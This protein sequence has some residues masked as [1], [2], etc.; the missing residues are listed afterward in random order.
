MVEYEYANNRNNEQIEASL[1]PSGEKYCCIECNKEMY[2]VNRGRIQTPHFRH[3]VETDSIHE[4][5]LHFNTKHL[6]YDYVNSFFVRG[7]PLYVEITDM[8]GFTHWYNILNN[9]ENIQKERAISNVYRPD[10]SIIGKNCIFSIEIVDTHSLSSTAN[11][12]IIENNINLIKLNVTIDVYRKIQNNFKNGINVLFASFNYLFTPFLSPINIVDISGPCVENKNNFDITHFNCFYYFGIDMFNT[13]SKSLEDYKLSIYENDAEKFNLKKKNELSIVVDEINKL[14]RE[15]EIDA[16]N[17]NSKKL[18]P[19][20]KDATKFNLKKQHEINDLM[21]PYENDVQMMLDKMHENDKNNKI[22]Y[23][24]E[25]FDE[26]RVDEQ[27]FITWVGENGQ[28]YL[29]YE[30]F[31][32]GRFYDIIEQQTLLN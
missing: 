3:K 9:V 28:T 5:A 30:P 13:F 21:L 2:V 18:L 24:R 20:E 15:Y 23:F 4:G 8:D 6:I 29:V 27:N 16:I 14:L 31:D 1:A 22:E 17:F 26:H 19:Y 10:V 7:L 12:Y 32:P 11:D 25:M